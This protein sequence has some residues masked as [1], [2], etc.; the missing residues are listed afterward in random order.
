MIEENQMTNR[1]DQADALLTQGKYQEAIGLLEAIRTKFPGEDQVLLRLAWASW[2][3]GNKDRSIEYWETL[4]DRELQ[5]KVFTG[6]AYDELVRIYKQE[7]RLDRLV[8]VCE[9]AVLV[10]PDDVGLLTELGLAYLLSCQHEKACETF[11]KLTAREGD[12]PVFH[13][14]LGEALLATGKR[15]EA[16]TAFEQ[17]AQI[18]PEEADR[19][20]FQ[21]VDLHIKAKQFDAA[22]HL[23]IKCIEL[24]PA[25]SLY[26]CSMGDILIALG[27]ADEAFAAYEQACG[28]NRPHAAAYFNRLG[29]SLM[30]VDLFARAAQ[31]FEIA[32]SYDATTPCRHQLAAAYQASGQTPSGSSSN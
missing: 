9:K 5:Y 8:S 15:K 31:A 7:G 11:K 28:H 10:Q 21:A 2:D 18:D 14:R 32:L 12:N 25:N 17:A 26:Y 3:N 29:N 20:Y 24:S 30:K 13:L 22:K 27:Q 23:L 16:L 19:Y 6:F 1:L 4:L